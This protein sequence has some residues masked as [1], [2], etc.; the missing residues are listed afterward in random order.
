MKIKRYLDPVRAGRLCVALSVSM[1][2]AGTASAQCE[3]E[4]LLA[5]DGSMIDQLGRAVDIDGDVAVVGAPGDADA[6]NNSGTAYVYQRDPKTMDWT[7]QQKL[8]AS[9]PAAFDFF[10]FS[11][12]IGGDLLIVGA[13]QLPPDAGVAYIFQRMGDVWEEMAVIGPCDNDPGD[14]F[15]SSVAVIGP[16]DSAVIGAPGDDELGVDA[17]AVYVF[18]HQGNEWVEQAKLTASNGASENR[19]GSSV[20][21][22]G[23]TIIVGAPFGSGKIGGTGAAYIFELQGDTWEEVASIGP[24]NGELTDAFG[25]AVAIEGDRALV[26]A[27]SHNAL[28]KESGA[29]YFFVREDGFWSTGPQK[30]VPADGFAGQKFGISVA[31]ANDRACIG[32]GKDDDAGINAGAAYFF[33]QGGGQ[34]AE[35]SKLTASDGVGGEFFGLAVALDED[36]AV[37]G[38]PL[39]DLNGLF[40][41]SAYVFDASTLEVPFALDPLLSELNLS[42]QVPGLDPQDFV[43]HLQGPMSA[44]VTPSCD[45]FTGIHVPSLNWTT[46]EKSLQIQL[47]DKNSILVS[48]LGINLVAPGAPAAVD[49]ENGMGILPNY[50]LEVV[51]DVGEPEGVPK[52]LLLIFVYCIYC[53]DQPVCLIGA[54]DPSEHHITFSDIDI[55]V[56]ADLGLGDLNPTVTITGS[57]VAFSVDALPCPWDLDGSGSVGAADLLTLLASWGPCKGCPADFD[58]SGNVG[59]SDL[60][61]L[62]ANW[63]PCP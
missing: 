9:N 12:S 22:S 51:G 49:E 17:G 29:A 10:G 41:G 55:S 31:L 5:S 53:F 6:G 25:S 58:D 4:N 1:G 47:P 63:G 45:A 23:E 24:T 27:P 20:A 33:M 28:G 32:V 54:G 15:G 62:L 48:D 30:I 57:I 52:I 16:C 46:V 39:D 50:G 3:L 42:I 21:V 8:V 59:A 35:I 13:P 19:F 36:D 26:G 56:E 11:V 44:T 34:W 7:E 2:A 60:L 40:A 38:E 18:V 14:S 43:I 37:I 61:A